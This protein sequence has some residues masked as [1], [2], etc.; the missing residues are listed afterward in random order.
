ML[1][2]RS[3]SIIGLLAVTM[4]IM[5]CRTSTEAETK[6]VSPATEQELIRIASQDSRV[7]SFTAAEPSYSRDITVLEPEN[8]AELSKTQPVM[9]GGLPG[10]ILYKIEYR[11]D[12]KGILVIVDLE[13]RKV[14]KYFRLVGVSLE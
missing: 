13:E 9:Y 5:S 12:G 1:K 6:R 10:K 8:I 2:K 11:S 14:L 3:I 7:Q 4:L